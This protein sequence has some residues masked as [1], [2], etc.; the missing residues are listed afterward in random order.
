[1][2][3]APTF[4]SHRRPQVLHNPEPTYHF[5]WGRDIEAE[6]R[7]LRWR[8][9]GDACHSRVVRVGVSFPRP[10]PR[11]S[12]RSEVR[13]RERSVERQFAGSSFGAWM[14]KI[15]CSNVTRVWATS[16]A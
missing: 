2:T 6:V 16:I 7:I 3:L 13:R 5:L 9:H 14:S 8:E 4:T 15:P 12:R 10:Q 1:M 11:C